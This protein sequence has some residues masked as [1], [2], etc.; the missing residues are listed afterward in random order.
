MYEVRNI[1][2]ASDLLRLHTPFEPFEV[3]FLCKTGPKDNHWL[4]MVSHDK[5]LWALDNEIQ[6]RDFERLCVD[7]LGREGYRHI[8]PNGGTKD[9]GKDAEIWFWHGTTDHRSVVAFQFSLEQKWERKLAEDAAKISVNCKNV[10]DLVFVTSRRVTGVKKDKLKT[11][12]RHKYGWELTIYE[13]EWL[14]NRLSEFHQDLAAKYL[15]VDL[16]PTVCFCVTQLELAGFDEKS[17]GEIFEHTSPELLRVSILERTRKEP[18]VINHWYHLAKIDY[19][20]RNYDSALEAIN[21]ALQLPSLDKV[22]TLNMTLSKGAILAEKGMKDGSRPLLIQAIEIFADASASLKRHVDIYNLANVLTALG[23][24]TEAGHLYSECVR[25]KPDFAQAWKNFGSLFVAKSRP[26]WGIECFEKA[27]KLEPGLVEAHLSKA[28]ALLIFFKEAEKAIQC[29]EAAYKIMPDL[30]R[31]WKYCRYWYSRSLQVTGRLEESLKQAEMELAIRPGDH[32]L[33]NQKGSVLHELRKQN[34]AC[35]EYA[36]EFF[37]FR[38]RAIPDDFA[39]L[40]E[41]IDIYSTRGQMEDA[42]LFIEINLSCKPVT[43]SEIAK[44]SGITLKDLQLGFQHARLYRNFRQHRTI[45]D[46]YI[47]LRNAGLAT[48]KA[49]LPALNYLLMAPFGIVAQRISSSL[50]QKETLDMQ[51]VFTEALNMVSNLLPAFGGHLLAPAKPEDTRTQ[52]DLIA[53]GMLN[54]FEIVVAEIARIEGFIAGKFDVPFEI[55]EKGQKADWNN[56]QTEIAVKL[57]G[58]VCRDWQLL[59]EFCLPVESPTSNHSGC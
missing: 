57:L 23:E 55:M 21:T 4:K 38:A 48:D 1:R 13:R 47:T 20:C 36:L 46:H 45:E 40:G 39:G 59:N 12:F 11:E 37:K 3:K 29:F 22:L 49:I 16:P 52:T 17:A 24:T 30:D 26:D 10:V 35:E 19:I 7:L 53:L 56:L 5:V 2:L 14:R 18:H 15:G 43:L 41:L 31:K 27:L 44:R 34:P 50:E 58:H 25:L 32:Y 33:L 54:V 8:E 51:A 28:T 9:N 42:W 6:P